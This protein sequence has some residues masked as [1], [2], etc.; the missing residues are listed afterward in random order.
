MAV[1]CVDREHTFAPRWDIAADL[2]LVCSIGGIV[3][4]VAAELPQRRR[5]E[6]ADVDPIFQ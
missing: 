6:L 2:E 3:L 5:P 1:N 4:G